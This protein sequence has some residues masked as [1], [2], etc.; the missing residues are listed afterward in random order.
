MRG[1]PALLAAIVAAGGVTLAQGQS[2]AASRG[3]T[4][5]AVEVVKARQQGLKALGAAFKVIR[6]E[7]Q[8]DAPDAAKVRKASADIAQAANAFDE[9]FPAGSGPDSGVRTNAKP[10]VWT[11]PV[12]FAAAREAF[13]R[14]ANEWAQVAKRADVSAWREG[15][16]SLG[17]RCK[18]CHDKYR[19]KRE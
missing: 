9:W 12:G 15:A 13:V 7:L 1:T 14:E 4:V 8:A 18:G 2:P 10:E 17:Q 5:S 3:Q 16:A 6:D 11:D 19:Q